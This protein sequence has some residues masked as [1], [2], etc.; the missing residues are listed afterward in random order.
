MSACASSRGAL[1]KRRISQQKEKRDYYAFRK[2]L[3]R[4]GKALTDWRRKGPIDP[5][6]G[7]VL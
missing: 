2:K 1:L 6:I 7:A 4:P 3:E 5:K